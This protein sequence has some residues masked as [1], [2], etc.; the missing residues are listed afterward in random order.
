MLVLRTVL[1]MVDTEIHLAPEEIM[2]GEEKLEVKQPSSS[3]TKL[4][5]LKEN[6][7]KE[8]K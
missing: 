6:N 8:F 7:M 2:A 1:M 4:I 3:L 5:H